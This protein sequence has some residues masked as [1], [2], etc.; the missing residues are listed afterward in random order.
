MRPLPPQWSILWDDDLHVVSVG[1]GPGTDL[2]G[3]LTALA[4]PPHGLNFTRVD[5]HTQWKIYYDAFR[6]DFAMQV[7][8]MAKLLGG[9]TNSFCK[10][11]LEQEEL[12]DSACADNLSSA[13][14]VILNRVLSTFQQNA[15]RTWGLVRE[16]ARIAPA[17]SLLVVIDVSLPRPEF[18]E[19]VAMTE[20]ACRLEKP[21]S[22]CVA[23][24]IEINET[25]FGW[26]IPQSIMKLERLGRR[27]T[28]SGRFFG[29]IIW[30]RK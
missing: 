18:Q 28:R 6:E 24:F 8:D 12:V 14:I 10:V 21:M 17:D 30:L 9:M 23:R 29:G 7:P 15:P 4:V 27:I 1:A 5:I 3:I 26:S 25:H 16:I 19:T 13:D 22:E 20:G 2:F 11:D